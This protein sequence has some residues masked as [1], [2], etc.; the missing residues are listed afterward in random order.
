MIEEVISMG[1]AIKAFKIHGTDEFTVSAELDV[2][3]PD[4]IKALQT[5]RAMLMMAY[6]EGQQSIQVFRKE[7]I[8]PNPNSELLAKA[9]IGGVGI[10]LPTPLA[11]P[12]S[13][14]G[15]VLLYVPLGMILAKSPPD[16]QADIGL[17][18]NLGD[19]KPYWF[20]S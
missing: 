16:I 1:L 6:K 7:R 4:S 14:S 19:G 9:I 12:P 5:F 15:V 3:K 10:S 20:N 13:N 18:W 11:K 2:T 17:P 8:F